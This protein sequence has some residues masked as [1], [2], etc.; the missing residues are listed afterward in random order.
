MIADD[1]QPQSFSVKCLL[2]VQPSTPL[3]HTVHFGGASKL[4]AASPS[5]VTSILDAHNMCI[6][7][8]NM[9]GDN[10]TTLT[11]AAHSTE[12]IIR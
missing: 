1:F 2:T 9:D 10:C 3:S 4:L 11:G 12:M 6:Q 8:E 5:Y 7:K